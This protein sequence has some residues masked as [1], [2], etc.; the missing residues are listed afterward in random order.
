MATDRPELGDVYE[1]AGPTGEIDSR[2]AAVI[3]TSFALLAF[4]LAK[5]SPEID[6]LGMKFTL[7]DARYIGVA[8]LVSVLYSS[9]QL[10]VAWRVQHEARRI[11]AKGFAAG[12]CL[13]DAPE[14][15][16]LQ[17]QQPW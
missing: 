7:D 14:L 10:G 16:L 12:R 13:R 8:L 4:A 1:A 5:S 6:I 9:A 3:V 11:P 15:E 17:G 2:A